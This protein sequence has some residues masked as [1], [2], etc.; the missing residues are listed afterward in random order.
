MNFTSI[1]ILFGK[2]LIVECAIELLRQALYAVRHNSWAMRMLHSTQ[3][4]TTVNLFL[5]MFETACVLTLLYLQYNMVS[6][7]VTMFVFTLILR[8][9]VVKLVR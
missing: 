8:Y 3:K 5:Q 9:F 6:I 4:N 7:I 2:T 1:L